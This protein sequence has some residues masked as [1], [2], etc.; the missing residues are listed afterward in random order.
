MGVSELLRL[1][2]GMNSLWLWMNKKH[3]YVDL[4][5]SMAFMTVGYEC[6]M[7]INKLIFTYRKAGEYNYLNFTTGNS[8][9][10]LLKVVQEFCS[11]TRTIMHFL[12]MR[13]HTVSQRD[14]AGC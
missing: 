10:D 13:F 5:A 6:L 7:H 12:R 9:R 3:K 14:Q 1:L 4:G 2:I 11:K 8:F